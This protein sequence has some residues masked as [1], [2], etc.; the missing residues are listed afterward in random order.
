MPNPEFAVSV[1]AEP[2]HLKAVRAFFQPVLTGYF[3]DEAHMLVLALDESCSNILKH[4]QKAAAGDVLTVKAT[5]LADLVRFQIQNFCCQEDI[6]NIRPR[7]LDC[8][9]P[10]GLGTHFIQEIMDRVAFEPDPDSP[11]RLT[12]VLEKA[13]PGEGTTNGS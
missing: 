1:P 6:P 5:V 13:L 8:V 11:G 2:S 10:G 9:R 3:G 7:D 12:L 4:Q